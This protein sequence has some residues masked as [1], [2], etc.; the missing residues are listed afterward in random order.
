MHSFI[1]TLCFLLFASCFGASVS[2]VAAVEPLRLADQPSNKLAPYIEYFREADDALNIEDALN[3]SDTQWRTTKA[4]GYMVLGLTEQAYWL[5]FSLVVENQKAWEFSLRYFFN[6]STDVYLREQGADKRAT[7]FKKI[8]SNQRWDQRH[9]SFPLPIEV[10]KTYDVYMR[11]VVPGPDKLALVIE[12]SEAKKHF[13][14]WD[15]RWVGVFYGGFITMLLY[16]LFLAISTRSFTY[17]YYLLYMI[18]MMSY[19]MMMDG[20]W[21]APLSHY[22]IAV[23]G[24]AAF[25]CKNWNSPIARWKKPI[26]SRT[27]FSVRSVTSSVLP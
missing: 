26:A 13:D 27:D 6:C 16:N 4:S 1:R 24:I 25:G 14:L 11:V 20:L 3:L 12:D 15:N 5:R 17:G 23:C 9:Y 21:Q 10:G 19:L 2:A 18:A 8:A 22:Y 7:A